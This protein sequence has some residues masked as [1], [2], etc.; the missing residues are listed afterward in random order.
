MG[1]TYSE[2]LELGH[3]CSAPA[4]TG[5]TYFTRGR[6]NEL[7]TGSWTS[8]VNQAVDSYTY[9][10]T[11]GA[12][13]FHY[14]ASANNPAVGQ[15]FYVTVTFTAQNNGQQICGATPTPSQSHVQAGAYDISP[16]CPPDNSPSLTNA[17]GSGSSMFCWLPAESILQDCPTEQGANTIFYIGQQGGGNAC[18]QEDN[19]SICPYTED[20]NYP[21]YYTPNY[22]APQSCAGQEPETPD[23][24]PDCT[25]GG[26]GMTVCKADPDDKCSVNST[27]LLSCE[28][29]CGYINGQFYCPEEP[30][31]PEL[32][33]PEISDTIQDPNK[34]MGD[35][36][37]QD[38][39]DVMVGAETRLSSIKKEL[40]D[41]QFN[42]DK[43]SD[44]LKDKLSGLGAKLDQVN[45][46][47]TGIQGTLD[48]TLYGDEF[49][50]D[51]SGFQDEINQGLGITGDESLADLE[52][53]PISLDD[54]SGNFQFSLGSGACPPDR[55]ITV[56]GQ[57]I[58][59][60][61]QPF[62]DI[63]SFIGVLVQITSYLLS[64]YI[65]FGGRK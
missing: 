48:E 62:C 3:I 36:L 46:N 52:Q 16:Y 6:S 29:G 49:S 61:W 26:N 31:I 59:I 7:F 57:A 13:I 10:Y 2:H 63:F 11:T 43:N 5:Q 18:I 19:G 56:A 14:S 4:P 28:S 42:N 39:K 24:K 17:F 58:A 8:V 45:R 12:C 51:S 40:E 15:S 65:V 37:K 33:D 27:G 20:P 23:L 22:S 32:P 41:L 54:F 53:D 21:G 55:Q 64:V 25:E 30:D 47:L 60:S 34:P 9:S 38:F 1:G 50:I 44:K 35:M